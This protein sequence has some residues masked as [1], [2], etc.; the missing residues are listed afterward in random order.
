MKAQRLRVTFT[1]GE[2]LKYITHLDMM[3]FWERTLRRAGLPLAY[4]EGFTPHVQIQIA[5]PL[6]VGTTTEADIMDVFLEERIP[7]RQF[8]ERARAA[9]P[10]AVSI[11]AV[12]EVGLTLPSLQAETR[13]AEY[14]V[15]VPSADIDAARDAVRRFLA[16][17]SVQWEHR[18]E[19]QLRS[20][21]IRA[22][23]RD[24]AVAEGHAPG[25]TR[26][27]MTLRNDPSGSGR[28]DQVVAALGL[29][30]PTRVHRTRLVLANTSRALEAWRRHGRFSE[31]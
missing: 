1:R 23:V 16:A 7:P 4:S 21:D 13:F 8:L 3:R 19:D 28:P 2:E 29:P 10:D 20:Y 24:I 22:L 14:E 5:A 15:E 27:R 31:R 9:L 11:A 25:Q 12:E 30:P 18:R 26:L 6:P 17:E